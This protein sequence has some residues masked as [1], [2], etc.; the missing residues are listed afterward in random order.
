MLYRGPDTDSRRATCWAE[1]GLSPIVMDRAVD[2]ARRRS[3]VQCVAVRCTAG[4]AKGGR[5]VMVAAGR[6]AFARAE[7]RGRECDT[8][9]VR[10]RAC[11]CVYYTTAARI[12]SILMIYVI[13]YVIVELRGMRG[14]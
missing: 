11:M 10:A 9:R 14:W 2:E 6:W 1:R 3:A 7:R 4:L 5:G 8:A 13:N 12:Y